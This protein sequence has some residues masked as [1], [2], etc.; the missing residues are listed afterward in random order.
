[1]ESPFYRE[2]LES[3]LVHS[4]NKHLLSVKEVMEYTGF[5]NAHSVKRRY[6]FVSG[7]ISAETLAKCLSTVPA[8]GLQR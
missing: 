4:K 3:I 5:T 2:N 8:K 7:Y 6:P 1:M